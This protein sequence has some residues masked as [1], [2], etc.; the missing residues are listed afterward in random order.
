[1]AMGVDLSILDSSVPVIR[2]RLAGIEDVD[3]LLVLRDAEVAGKT[4]KGVLAAIDDRVADLED[5]LDPE[6]SY[7]EKFGTE[8]ELDEDDTPELVAPTSVGADVVEFTALVRRQDETVPGG[9]YRLADGRLVNAEGD[10]IDEI[11]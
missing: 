8:P 9:R 6:D 1:M 3:A 7:E 11:G 4:R 2:E 10:E 5:T